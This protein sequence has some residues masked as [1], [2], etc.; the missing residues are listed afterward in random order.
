MGQSRNGIPASIRQRT[1]GVGVLQGFGVGRNIFS[2]NG[3]SQR[4]GK[5]IAL[6][7]AK[8]ENQYLERCLVLDHI[9]AFCAVDCT[10]YI[11]CVVAVV[12][13]SI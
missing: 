3:Q 5:S 2:D 8:K 11:W 9:V 1:R 13:S 6:M 12:G 7:G 10:Q 4:D